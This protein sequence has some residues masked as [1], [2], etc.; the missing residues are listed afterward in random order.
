LNLIPDHI[1][2]IVGFAL[3]VS[4]ALSIVSPPFAVIPIVIFFWILM[5]LSFNNREAAKKL[6]EALYSIKAELR[7]I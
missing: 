5:D 2:S 1:G 7:T 4:S 6:Q 3:F